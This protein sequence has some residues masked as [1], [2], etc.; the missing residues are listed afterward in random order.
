MHL[1]SLRGKIYDIQ[2]ELANAYLPINPTLIKDRL[3]NK[4]DDCKMFFHLFEE[5]N[6]QLEK[7]LGIDYERSTR[8][9]YKTCLSYFREMYRKEYSKTTDFP[10]KSLSPDMIQRFEV[11]LRA[12]KHL[13]NNTMIRFMKCVKKIVNHALANGWI[14]SN[15][16]AMSH[17]H[18]E[19][20]TPT[21]ITQEELECLYYK[22]ITIPRLEIVK[23]VY[24]FCC[25]TGLAFIDVKSLR[26]EHI[27]RDTNGAFWIRK[28]RTKTNVMCNIPLFEI[29]LS[30]IEKY[31][32]HPKCVTENV[33]FP[34]AS[35]QK[36][37]GYL[38]E[39]ADICGINKW[40]TTHT[41]RRTF[42]TTLTLGNGVALE[43]VSKMLGHTNTKMTQHY[44]RV[45]DA[46]IARDM[47]NVRRRL[48]QAI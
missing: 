34:V 1:D 12:E 6:N 21:F 3:L 25:F 19:E 43:N 16:F 22:E 42:A 46:S 35:N 27:F 26:P 32:D 2:Q 47:D 5:H 38:K 14:T 8:G 37:N 20:V 36:M 40:L 30:L 31:S 45:Q 29:P 11:F 7:L 28:A 10:V 48:I 17:Y 4:Q 33:L 39:L 13:A 18:N 24:I 44:A 23:D 41:A 9:R 15:P